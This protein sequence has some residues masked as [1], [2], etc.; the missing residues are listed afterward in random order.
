MH[1]RLCKY[2][3]ISTRDKV[4]DTNETVVCSLMQVSFR[5]ECRK[6][7]TRKSTGN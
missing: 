6:K 5:L 1:M 7:Q 2:N 4:S 3:T